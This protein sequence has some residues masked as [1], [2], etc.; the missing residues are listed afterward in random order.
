VFDYR[1]IEAVV[2]KGKREPVPAGRRCLGD[3]GDAV[4]KLVRCVPG[5]Q[6]ALVALSG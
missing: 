1:E 4:E 6:A 2:A 3:L 5:R